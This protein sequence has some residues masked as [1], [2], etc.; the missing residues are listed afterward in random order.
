MREYGRFDENVTKYFAVQIL[1]GAE[2]LHSRGISHRVS[3]FGSKMFCI[4]LILL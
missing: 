2:Y 1:A 3:R 4:R